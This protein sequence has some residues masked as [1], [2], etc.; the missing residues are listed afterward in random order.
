MFN[1]HRLRQGLVQSRRRSGDAAPNK[2]R[3]LAEELR[4]ES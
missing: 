2:S 3:V 1:R 4:R